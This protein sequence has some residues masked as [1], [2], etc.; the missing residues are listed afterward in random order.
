MLDKS[1]QSAQIGPVRQGTLETTR[2]QVRRR[3]AGLRHAEDGLSKPERARTPVRALS[4]LSPPLGP[5][6]PRSD[7]FL[8]GA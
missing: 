2:G 1:P 3:G 7:F 8:L 4:F 5:D 6:L